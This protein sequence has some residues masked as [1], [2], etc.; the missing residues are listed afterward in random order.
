MGVV[1]EFHNSINP[2]F[3]V[4]ENLVHEEEFI[5]ESPNFPAED[6]DIHNV[7]ADDQPSNEEYCDS[8][9]NFLTHPAS[10]LTRGIYN[11]LLQAFYMRHCLSK[12]C[13]CNTALE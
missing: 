2:T 3:G 9:D 13:Q 8:T 6:A 4:C 1:L 5:L 11:S 10:T 12:T 7:P